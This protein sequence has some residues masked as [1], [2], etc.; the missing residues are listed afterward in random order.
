[1]A[2][3]QSR[4]HSLL[5]ANVIKLPPQLSP[6]ELQEV[7]KNDDRFPHSTEEVDGREAENGHS[8]PPTSKPRTPNSP[9]VSHI[10]RKL[11][12]KIA[13]PIDAYYAQRDGLEEKVARMVI[14]DKNTQPV[15]RDSELEERFAE[16]TFRHRNFRIFPMSP[17]TRVG[18]E[19]RGVRLTSGFIVEDDGEPAQ[20][21]RAEDG[22]WA[23]DLKGEFVCFVT[24]DDGEFLKILERGREWSS[25]VEGAWRAL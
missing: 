6:S 22:W 16:I 24:G 12:E 3:N 2:D 14:D 1:M 5:P 17:L 9:S 23:W 11:L 21:V 20:I 13:A 8:R 18:F 15:L 25:A 10:Y 4:L 19:E 7:L